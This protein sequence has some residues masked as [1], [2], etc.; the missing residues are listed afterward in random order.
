MPHLR[1]FPRKL[2]PPPLPAVPAKHYGR[3]HLEAWRKQRDQEIAGPDGWLTLTG[4]EWLQKGVNSFGSAADNK[5][6]IAASAPAHIGLLTVSGSTGCDHCARRDGEPAAM[7][8]PSVEPSGRA[9]VD[10]V[11]FSTGGESR[12]YLW[13]IAGLIPGLQKE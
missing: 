8:G 10:F 13:P 4:L 5:I 2:S 11:R 1:K 6:H 12:A 3:S 7:G 9:R